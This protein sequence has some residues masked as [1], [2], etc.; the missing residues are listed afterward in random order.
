MY[1]NWKYRLPFSILVILSGA[2][3]KFVVSTT[4]RPNSDIL[5]FVNDPCWLGESHGLSK[6]VVTI[7][8]SCGIADVH[9]L[10]CATFL[11][12]IDRHARDRTI[13]SLPSLTRN[14]AI[15]YWFIRIQMISIRCL[16]YLQNTRF[17]VHHCLQI[18]TGSG[19]TISNFDRLK[20]TTLAMPTNINLRY[21]I[22]EE[23]R[24]LKSTGCVVFV[25][26]FPCMVLNEI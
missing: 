15:M 21:C 10:I 16:F 1:M 8:A 6:T 14:A 4:T 3:C 11:A 22:Y 5:A 12:F 19:L 26:S 20:K 24:K 9:K 7:K 17:I 25:G 18:Y 13:R 23:Q 2:V